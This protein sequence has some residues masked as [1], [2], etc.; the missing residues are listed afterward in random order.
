MKQTI[1][2]VSPKLNVTRKLY[3]PDLRPG[4][5]LISLAGTGNIVEDEEGS[6]LLLSA[7]GVGLLVTVGRESF[8]ARRGLAAAMLNFR[9]ALATE[10][11]VISCRRVAATEFLLLLMVTEL[12]LF[13]SFMKLTLISALKSKNC[14]SSKEES[15]SCLK[16]SPSPSSK[17]V[18]RSSRSV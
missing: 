14:S 9:A 12:L 11:F 3:L 18:S 16:M 4:S 15:E 17:P 13:S 1:S 10:F 2:M 7:E 5:V 6:L 8:S